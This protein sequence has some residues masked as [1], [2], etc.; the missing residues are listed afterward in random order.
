MD[1]TIS[2]YCDYISDDYCDVMFISEKE[3]FML[4]GSEWK[5][6]RPTKADEFQPEWLDVNESY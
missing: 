2:F 1:Y 6:K 4:S 3:D 5:I